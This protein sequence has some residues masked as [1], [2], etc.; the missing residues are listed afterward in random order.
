M[1]AN[2]A[3]VL[4][5]IAA[6]LWNSSSVAV[7]VRLQS[8][9]L[10]V[11]FVLFSRS[12]R[13]KECKRLSKPGQVVHDSASSGMQETYLICSH[14]TLNEKRSLGGHN[15]SISTRAAIPAFKARDCTQGAAPETKAR[16]AMERNVEY[17]FVYAALEERMEAS[18]R[19]GKRR[20]RGFRNGACIANEPV[21]GPKKITGVERCFK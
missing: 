10:S 2:S 8:L 19:R 21:H 6:R 4:R 17:R 13:P 3:K 5:Q 11:A 12:R 7:S 18:R 9:C 1:R 14:C 16:G 20:R 15:V